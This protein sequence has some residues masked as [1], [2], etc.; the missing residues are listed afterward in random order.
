MRGIE[1][2]GVV[3]VPFKPDTPL[4]RIKLLKEEESK[5]RH[6]SLFWHLFKQ[7]LP[8]GKEFRKKAGLIA[9]KRRRAESGAGLTHMARIGGTPGARRPEAAEQ[10][11]RNSRPHLSSQGGVLSGHWN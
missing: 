4:I 1:N 3:V 6:P 11:S 7:Q 9:R 8:R 5:V 2:G 10:P